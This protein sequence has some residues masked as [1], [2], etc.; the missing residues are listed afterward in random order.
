LT[1]SPLRADG[2]NRRTYKVLMIAPTSFF[3]DYGCHVRILEE[4]LVLQ[5]LGNQVTICT[6]HNGR[7]MTGLDIR[8]TTAIPWRTHYEVGSSRHK[9]AFDALLGLTSLSTALRIKPDIVHG[10]L[11]E[12]ALLGSLV[13]AV[14]GAPLIFDMQGSMTGEMVDHRFLN[15]QGAFYRPARFLEKVID[16]MPAAIV[17]SSQH[18]AGQLQSNFGCSADRITVISDC[19]NADSFAPSHDQ[20]ALLKLRTRLGIPVDRDVVVYLGLLAE[21]QGISILLQAARRLVDRRANTQFL[22][23]GYPSVNV[24][25]AKASALGLDGNVTFTGKIP[26]EDAPS[27][28]ALGQVAVAPKLS[29]TEGSG[30]LLNYMSMS[31]PTVAFDVSVSREYMNAMGTYATPGDADSLAQALES[32]LADREKALDLGQRLRRRAIEH[33]SWQAAGYRIMDVYDR[34]CRQ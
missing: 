10:H 8:R 25:R 2:A 32:L 18:A 34:A 3:A 20:D 1:S 19:V 23:M 28:L 27:Y 13:S 14:T 33:F 4:A 16:H 29:A 17:T 30:K 7:N 6:Y 31:L 26:Y 12:G 15:P 22:I 5:Q 21:W 24:Y 9:I 11:H